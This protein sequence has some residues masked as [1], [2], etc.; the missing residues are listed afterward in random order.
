[1][2][3]KYIH[4]LSTVQQYMLT[5]IFINDMLSITVRA[6]AVPRNNNHRKMKDVT[7]KNNNIRQPR[8]PHFLKSNVPV[9]V[10]VEPKREEFSLFWCFFILFYSAD[11]YIQLKQFEKNKAFTIE[12]TERFKLIDMVREPDNKRK[13]KELKLGAMLNIETNLAYDGD[14]SIQTFITLCV[15]CKINTVVEDG[16]IVYK[17]I[18][19][20]EPNS[21]IFLISRL[22]K[23]TFCMSEQLSDDRDR[24]SHLMNVCGNR[25]ALK[26]VSGYTSAQLLDMCSRLDIQVP[27]KSTKSV[28][29][30]SI[31]K[32]IT[33]YNEQHPQ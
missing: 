31:V 20:D 17:N 19:N 8:P 11:T 21:P 23:N 5:D 28:M 30:E 13:I 33:P 9:P 4:I 32:F 24:L 2:S 7:V 29:Y 10:H 14:I 6:I 16:Q 26:S 12:R 18:Y 1:M 3:S 22:S 27:H 15:L 25:F